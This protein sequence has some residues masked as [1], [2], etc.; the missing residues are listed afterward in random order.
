MAGFN[1][2]VLVGNLCRDPELKY[3]PS[4]TAIA[5][6]SLAVT[7]KKKD[8][9][10]TVFI[11]ITAW[12]RQAETCCEYLKKGSSVLVEGRLKLDQWDDK[13]S[14]KKRSKIS[15]TAQTVQ[16]LGGKQDGDQ[17]QERSDG[18]NKLPIQ[19]RNNNTVKD[20]DCPF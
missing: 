3:T 13:E 19:D 18:E 12:E 9:D 5:N 2:V 15:V 1:R 17:R 16:F 20:D 7:T 8:G 10:D 4:G 14:G 11:D 6:M